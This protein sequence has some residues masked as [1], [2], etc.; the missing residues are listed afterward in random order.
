MARS[1]SLNRARLPLMHAVSRPLA[2][3]LGLM[4]AAVLSAARLHAG[5]VELFEER[6]LS[7]KV[8]GN[9]SD[10]LRYN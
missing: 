5:V 1:C 3:L 8:E 6:E 9:E 2:V 7:F 4:L 10:V